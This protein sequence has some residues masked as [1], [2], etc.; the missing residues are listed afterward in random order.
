MFDNKKISCMEYIVTRPSLMFSS[1]RLCPLTRMKTFLRVSQVA[2]KCSGNLLTSLRGA[3]LCLSY[4]LGRYCSNMSNSQGTSDPNIRSTSKKSQA[5]NGE[6]LVSNMRAPRGKRLNLSISRPF[7]SYLSWETPSNQCLITRNS[8]S[9]A[10]C[11]PNGR[12]DAQ[13]QLLATKMKSKST[14]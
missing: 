14:E 4:W 1:D 13:G 8:E 12:R 6:V 11:D 7:C 5:L 3:D 9:C 10:V 2:V